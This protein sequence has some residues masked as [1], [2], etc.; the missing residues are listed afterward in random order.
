MTILSWGELILGF[1]RQLLEF[2]NTKVLKK[3]GADELKVEQLE[4][5]NVLEDAIDRGVSNAGKL[6]DSEILR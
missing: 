3:A 2:L 4:K 5:E 1:L 6:P